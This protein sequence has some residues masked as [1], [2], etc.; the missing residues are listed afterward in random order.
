VQVEEGLVVA[1]VVEESVALPPPAA[2]TV[3][4]EER[5]VT[6]TTAPQAASEPQAGTSSG[7][8]DVVMVS[9]DEGAAPPL[10]TRE[11]DATA[12]VAPESSA[13]GTAP[14]IEGAEDVSMSR[15]LTIP[16]IG[17]I[18]LDA[19]ELPRNDREILEAVTDQVFID[20]SLLDAIVLEPPAPR[21]D[22]DVGGCASYATP[23]AAE[24]VP[25]E[26]AAGTESAAM[27]SPPRLHKRPR[28]R[29]CSS[30]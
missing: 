5:V 4:E 8:E 19:T 14:S 3:V 2:A 12:S 28:T 13:A 17:V 20:P 21:Q 30:L 6:E 10:P 11:R 29:P 24:G 15:Y 1:V 9:A 23:E 7:G 27:A 18:D 26:S 16:G 25:G 22:E